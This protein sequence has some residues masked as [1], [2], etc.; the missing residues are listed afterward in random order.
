MR[1]WKGFEKI[2]VV[3]DRK[4]EEEHVE[5]CLEKK[6]MAETDFSD[7]SDG[8]PVDRNRNRLQSIADP[9][10]ERTDQPLLCKSGENRSGGRRV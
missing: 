1:T 9:F 4:N 7:L 10:A 3:D 5:K 6:K 2:S 8:Q